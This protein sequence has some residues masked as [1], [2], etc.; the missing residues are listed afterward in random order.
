ML[1]KLKRKLQARLQRWS[2]IGK[3]ILHK[4]YDWIT[5]YGT[6]P[7]R[8]LFWWL[9]LFVIFY[10]VSKSWISDTFLYTL[11]TA[12]P[13]ARYL[14]NIPVECVA[15]CLP[16]PPAWLQTLAIIHSI[17]STV[18]LFWSGFALRGMF[19]MR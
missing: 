3:W 15:E 19:R 17:V 10:L 18:L 12:L 16:N 4:L 5:V 11:R 6:S 8:P 14:V 1:D 9:V 13:P 7:W 2:L